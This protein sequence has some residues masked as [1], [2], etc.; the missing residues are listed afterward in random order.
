MP[1]EVEVGMVVAAG[2]L[3]NPRPRNEVSE[4]EMRAD[5]FLKADPA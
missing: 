2:L 5:L 4:E 3:V 1:V